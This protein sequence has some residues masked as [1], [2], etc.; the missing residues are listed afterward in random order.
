MNESSAESWMEKAWHNLSAAKLLFEAN[1][2]TDIIAV[3]LHYAIEKSLK[4]FLAYENKKIPK[5]HDLIELYRISRHFIEFDERE[6]DLL[7]IATEYHIRESYPQFERTLPARD[8]IREVLDFT[9]NLFDEV[10]KKLD[11]D[12]KDIEL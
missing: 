10:L 6:I 11:I 2:Y 8:E 9:E 12:R 1:H 4:S 7:I 5:T 3:E